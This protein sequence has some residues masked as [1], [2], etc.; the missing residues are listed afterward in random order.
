FMKHKKLFIALTCVLSFFAAIFIFLTIWFWGDRY[1]DLNNNFRKEFSIEGL[2]DGAV[3]QGMGNCE[4]KID[5]ATE[6]Y[7]F[8]SA[9]MK[10]G[11]ASRIYVTG[12]DSGY[13][14]YVTMKNVDGSDYKGHCGGLATNGDYLWVT[15]ED[16]VYVTKN[17]GDTTVTQDI[18]TRAKESGSI[19]FTASFAANCGA[20]FCYYF[21]TKSSK[22]GRLYIGEFY[23]KGTYDKAHHRATTKNGYENHAYMY[24]YNVTNSGDYGL[25]L[26]SGDKLNKYVPKIQNVISIPEKIQGAA[27]SGRTTNGA[28]N[29]TLLLS[30]SYSL[31][32][33]H[34]YS[35]NWNKVNA[36]HE[37]TT[38]KYD[39]ITKN[40]ADYYEDANMFFADLND[41]DM[42]INDYSLP[43]MS[44]GMC[45]VNN[46]VYVL[47]E[48]GCKKYSLFVREK[49]KNVY[50]F[51]PRK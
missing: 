16:N 22:T 29:G 39:G 7:F 47:F 13:I 32:N 44:E 21:A 41:K 28:S 20:D 37:I 34:I 45:T 23:R 24:E 48:S 14:G 11:S 40:N 9:Y 46:R 38:L 25:T 1:A 43:S 17:T 4:V 27:F 42:L 10:N 49:M 5:N 30:Q 26:L 2:K 6:Q 36:Y 19:Q 3:P 12:A 35:F 33:S 50:S 18:V 51:I 8:T 31:A 15:G